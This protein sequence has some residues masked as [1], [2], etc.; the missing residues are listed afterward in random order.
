MN[1][2]IHLWVEPMVMAHKR[3]PVDTKVYFNAIIKG[4]HNFV[5][6]EAMEALDGSLMASIMDFGDIDTNW[7]YGVV[8]TKL[9]T[10]PVGI[11]YGLNIEQHEEEQKEKIHQ[12]IVKQEKR[13]I[14]K[15][16][17]QIAVL[18]GK[19]LQKIISGKQELA[20]TKKDFTIND[21]GTISVSINDLAT[22][23]TIDFPKIW[24]DLEKNFIGKIAEGQR[25]ELLSDSGEKIFE[26]VG[27]SF[28]NVAIADLHV[29]DTKTMPDKDKIGLY[30]RG[31]GLKGG[32]YIRD[33]GTLHIGD[34]NRTF[35]LSINTKNLIRAALKANKSLMEVTKMK[36]LKP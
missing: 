34:F 28:L 15:I 14:A 22:T 11:T 8:S 18:K 21:N 24:L 33:D 17:S 31:Q 29:Y 6:D 30:N 10:K 3:C 16:N 4:K 7:D 36:L 5:N 26:M 20:I 32:L 13:K 2:L 27:G 25:V 19:K 9:T 23:E 12:K 1:T 35:F